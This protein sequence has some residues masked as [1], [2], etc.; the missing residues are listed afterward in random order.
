[1]D[2]TTIAVPKLGKIAKKA[3]PEA[4]ATWVAQ[5]ESSAA[6]TWF[7][8]LDTADQ[9]T[10]TDE[11]AGFCE[12]ANFDLAWVVQSQV[13]NERLRLLL[14]SLVL[15]HL[16]TN[17][18]AS[19]AQ[20]GLELY[21]ALVAWL[22]KPTARKYRQQTRQIY[23]KLIE[24]DVIPAAS[25]DTLLGTDKNRWKHVESVVQE[26]Y[27]KHPEAVSQAVKAVLLNKEASISLM[28]RLSPFG[29]TQPPA[30]TSA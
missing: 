18:K 1:M 13:D 23:V 21:K 2:E 19:S 24:D 3:L 30:A 6:S 11:I 20:A 12:D 5:Q 22:S 7:A 16:D 14:E 17:Y 28:Q 4:F 15:S 9:A 25:A 26:A 29:R 8:N 27:Q 10:I